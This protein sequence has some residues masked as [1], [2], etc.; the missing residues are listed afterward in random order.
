[1]CVCVGALRI[2]LRDKHTHNPKTVLFHPQSDF[3]VFN[4]T[5]LFEMQHIIISVTVRLLFNKL[6]KHD[7]KLEENKSEGRQVKTITS[8]SVCDLKTAC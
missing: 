6:N 2:L 4:L 5:L 1:M 7:G 3:S 8:H